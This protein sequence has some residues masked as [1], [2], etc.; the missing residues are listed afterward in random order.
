MTA[1]VR[2]EFERW[3]GTK[4]VHPS[5]VQF[6]HQWLRGAWA[7][8][9]HQQVRIADLTR[10]LAE[11]EAMLTD[12]EAALGHAGENVGERLVSLEAEVSRYQGELLEAL[13]ER[14]DARALLA[15]RKWNPTEHPQ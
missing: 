2:E 1:N 8:W 3:H 15:E 11:G 7:A 10:Q 6:A 4:E 9:Q 14:D 5:I 13:K 12:I